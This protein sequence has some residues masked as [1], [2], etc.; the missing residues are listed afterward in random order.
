V[1]LG[2]GPTWPGCH[3][4]RVLAD[5]DLGL[6]YCRGTPMMEVAVDIADIRL[7]PGRRVWTLAGAA[8]QHAPD[9]AEPP[10]TE[11]FLLLGDNGWLLLHAGE[12]PRL[13]VS[14]D[15]YRIVVQP[16]FDPIQA[17]LLASFGLPLVLSDQPIL[18][19]HAA[20]L[21]REGTA[22]LVAG[23][24]GTGKS[25]SLVGL[26]DAGWAPLSEDVCVIEFSRNDVRV[27]PGPPWVRRR[28]GEPGPTG[29]SPLFSTAGKTAWDLSEW[30]PVD[31]MPLS[32]L[33]LLERP[34][35][36]EPRWQPLDRPAATGA[37]AEHAVWLGDQDEGGRHL[38]GPIV[39]LTGWVPVARLRLPSATGWLDAL[40]MELGEALGQR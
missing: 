23:A 19:F 9:R 31:A 14:P 6:G 4:V 8:S 22:V 20:G 36:T 7:Q 26:T 30:R 1:T 12:M 35:G 25:S 38:F 33:I 34:G 24:S 40:S 18:I 28:E 13:A 37:L 32:Q 27:W 29:S 15:R 21:A 10:S 5:R 17:Q 11:Q 39:R 3:G 2:A 16:P